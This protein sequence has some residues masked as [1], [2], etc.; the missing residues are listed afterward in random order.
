MDTTVN[1]EAREDAYSRPLDSIDASVLEFN[2]DDTPRRHT[3]NR[4]RRRTRRRNPR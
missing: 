2:Q 1:V 3:R 4:W